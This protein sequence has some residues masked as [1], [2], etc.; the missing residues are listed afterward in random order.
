MV[1]LKPDFYDM[2]SGDLCEAQLLT[3]YAYL[4]YSH[5]HYFL[6]SNTENTVNFISITRVPQCYN[7]SRKGEKT[8]QD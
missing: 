2:G 6:K 5:W 1:Y 4:L 3:G 7:I 8:L